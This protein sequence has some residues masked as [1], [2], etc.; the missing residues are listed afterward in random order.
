MVAFNQVALGD[1]MTITFWQR[2]ETV[3]QSL[4]FWGVS[5]T[6]LIELGV[7]VHAPWT[8]KRIYFDTGPNANRIVTGARGDD[9]SQWHHFTF[10]KAGPVKQVWLDGVLLSQAAGAPSIPSDFTEFW[11]GSGMQGGGSILGQLDDFAIFG[12]ALSQATIVQLARGKR[13]DE[14]VDDGDPELI[15][16]CS[17]G[18]IHNGGDLTLN[19]STVSGNRALADGGAIYNGGNLTLNDSTV[20]GNSALAGGGGI[21]SDSGALALNRSTVSDNRAFSSGG[22]IHVTGGGTVTIDNSTC[23]GNSGAM[24]GAVYA[25]DGTITVNNTTMTGNSA[26]EVGGAMFVDLGLLMLNNSTV[27]GNSAEMK[28]GGLRLSFGFDTH[29][30]ANSIVAGNTALSGSGPDIWTDGAPLTTTGV[31][32]IG[33]LDGSGLAPDPTVLV[34][35]PQLEPLGDYG[36]PTLTMQPQPGSP[37]INPPGGATA[38]DFDYDQRGPGFRR[39]VGGVLDIGAVEYPPLVVTTAVDEDDG[40]ALPSLGTGISLREALAASAGG[41]AIEF[42]P[43]LSGATITLLHGEMVIDKNIAISAATLPDGLTISGNDV[44][45][46]FTVQSGSTVVMTSLTLTNGRAGQYGGAIK[47]HGALTLNRVRLIDN[48]SGQDGGAIYN[49]GGGIAFNECTA[50]DNSAPNRYGGVLWTTSGRDIIVNGSTFSG[51]T[52][53]WG[54]AIYVYSGNLTVNNSTLAQNSASNGGAIHIQ[55]SRLTLYNSTVFGNSATERGG[56][57]YSL[58]SFISLHNAIMAGNSAALAPDIRRTGLASVSA[59]GV[60]LIGDLDGSGMGEGPSVRVGDPLLAPLG[61]YGGPTRTMLPLPGS[62]AIDAGGSSALPSDQRGLPRAVGVRVDIGAVETGNGIPDYDPVVDSSSDSIDGRDTNGVS[63]REAVLL[64]PPDAAITFDPT[65]EDEVITLTGGQFL[66]D[67]NLTIDGSAFPGGMTLSGNNASRLFEIASGATVVICALNLTEGFA[68]EGGAVLNHGELTINR[69]TVSGNRAADPYAL[70]SSHGGGIVNYGTLTINYSTVSDNRAESYDPSDPFGSPYGEAGGGVANH[71]YLT[72]NNSTISGNRASNLNSGFSYFPTE[73]GGIANYGA[74]AINNSTISG[75]SAVGQA[76]AEARG[77]AI[78]N[79]GSSLTLD[80]VTIA[81]NSADTGGGGLYS[82]SSIMPDSTLK[83]SII[84]GNTAPSGPDLWVLYELPPPVTE[85]VNLIGDLTDS[86]LTGG[87]TVMTGDPLLAPLGPYGGPTRTMRPLNQSPVIDAAAE[88]APAADQRGVPRPQGDAADIGAVEVMPLALTVDIAG[89]VD[90]GP[91]TNGTSLREAVLYSQGDTQITFDESLAGNTIL[92]GLGEFLIDKDLDL[93]ASALSSG[94]TLDARGESRLF[95]VGAGTTVAMTNLRLTGGNAPRGGGILNAGDLT[96]SRVTISGNFAAEDGGGIAN[97][98]GSLTLNESTVAGNAAGSGGGILNNQGTLALHKSTL[99]GNHAELDGGGVR[100]VSGT[101]A[102]LDNSTLSGNTAGTSGGGIFTSGASAFTLSSVTISGNSAAVGGGVAST[103]STVTLKNSIVAANV[104]PLAPDF[105]D[106]GALGPAGVNLLSDL[107]GTEL[108]AGTAVLVTDDP[109]LAP[110]GNYGGPTKTLLPLPDSPAIDAAGSTDPGGTDQRGSSRFVAGSLDIGAVEVKRLIVTTN[111]ASGDGSLQKAVEEDLSVGT[112]IGFAPELSGK[113]ITLEGSPITITQSLAVDGSNLPGGITISGD[114]QSRVFEVNAEATVLLQGLVMTNGHAADDGGGIRNSGTLILRD[115]IL[116]RSSAQNDGG[117]I[118]NQGALLLVESLVSNN[119]SGRHGGGIYHREGSPTTEPTLGLVESTITGN[120][121]GGDGGGLYNKDGAGVLD[122]STFSLNAADGDGGAILN[123]LGGSL[124]LIESMLAGNSAAGSGGGISNEGEVMLNDSSITGNAAALNGGGVRHISGSLALTTGTISQNTAGQAGGGIWSGATANVVDSTIAGNT[125][126]N[127]GGVRHAGGSLTLT[128]ATVADNQSSGD[129]GGITSSSGNLALSAVTISGNRAAASGGGLWENPAGSLRLANVLLAGNRAMN[130]N[131]LDGAVTGNLGGNLLGDGSGATGLVDGQMN[132]QVGTASEPIDPGLAPLGH[133]GGLTKT[134]ALL[135]GSPAIDAGLSGDTIPV[136]DQRGF[137]R[138]AVPDVGAAEAAPAR[139]V[140]TSA[141]NGSGSLRQVLATAVGGPAR[142]LFN[143]SSDDNTITLTSGELA[144]SSQSI[145]LDA[146]KLVD[147]LGDVATEEDP[148]RSGGRVVPTGVTISGGHASRVFDVPDGSSLGLH[149]VTVADGNSGAADGGGLLVEGTATLA[150]C[151][152]SGCTTTGSGGGIAS[153]G[154]LHV[155]N[156]TLS[157]NHAAYGGAIHQSGGRVTIN[158]STLANNLAGLGGGALFVMDDHVAKPGRLMV[159]GSTI[160]GN[161]A[162]VNGGVGIL[163]SAADVVLGNAIVAGN[164]GGTSPDLGINLSEGSFES[165]GGNLIGDNRGA[166]TVFPAGLPNAGGDLAGPAADPLDP[167]L[168]NLADNGGPTATMA[169]LP[170]SPAVDAGVA[171]GHIPF[172]DQRGLARLLA[173]GLDIGALEAGAVDFTAS[174]LTLYAR[175]P[176]AVGGGG[177]MRFEIST[178]PDFFPLVSTL[179]G[180]GAVGALDGAV[181]NARFSYPADLAEDV[182]GNLFIADSGNNLIRMITPGGEVRTIAGTGNFGMIDGIGAD[183]TFAFPSGLAVGPDGNLYVSDTINHV[184]RKLTR[185]AEADDPWIVSTLAGA[186]IAGFLDGIGTSTFFNHPHGIAVDAS[187]ILFVADTFNHC[188]RKISPNGTVTTYAGSGANGADDGPR[189]IARFSSPT[190][191]AVDLDGNVFVADRDN[192]RIRMI[193]AASHMVVTIAG[194]SAGFLNGDGT[195][196]QFR[197]PSGLALDADGGLVVADQGNHAIRHVAR[198]ID[199]ADP[200]KVSTVAGTGDGG[201][202][203]GRGTSVEAMFHHCNGVLVAANGDVL[204][205]DE[206][207]HRIRRITDPVLITASEVGPAPD[208]LM[209]SR[210]LDIASLGLRP[211]LAYYFR[212]AAVDGST[213]MLGASFEIMPLP[214]VATAPATNLTRTAATING[215]VDPNGSP[216]TVTFE[217]ST[218][219]DLNGPMTVGSLA[220]GFLDPEGV[221]IDADG[222]V[223]LA[224]RDAHKILRIDPVGVVSDFAGSGAAGFSDGVGA[225]AQFD[226]PADVAID[227]VG[228]V[229][230]A[231]E[232]NHRIRM[233]TPAGAVSTVAG[234][235]VA[236]DADDPVATNGRLLFP[237]GVA[238]GPEGEV[239]IADRGNHRIRVVSGGG[240][241]TLAGDGTPGFLDGPAAAAQFNNPTGVAV[242]A[243]GN[244]YVA[245][246]DNHR[247]RLVAANGLVVTAAGTGM[248]GYLDGAGNSARFAFPTGVAVDDRGNLYVA[249]YGNHRLRLIGNSGVVRTAAGSGVEAVLDSPGTRFLYP[250]TAAGFSS[251]NRVAVGSDGTIFLTEQGSQRVRMVERN[252]LR[253]ITLPE[254]FGDNGDLNLSRTLPE[255]LLLG[256]TYY[257][258]VCAQNAVGPAEGGILSFTTPTNP[259]IAVARGAGDVAVALANGQSEPVDFGPTPRGTP[260]TL[261]FTITNVGG[262]DLAVNTIKP[263]AG[264]QVT[265]VIEPIAPGASRYFEVT[266]AAT[267]GGTFGGNLEIVSND[268]EQVS[269]IFPVTGTVLDPPTL[270]MLNASD[271]G[272]GSAT[273]HATVNPEDSATTV[274]FEYS[275]DPNLEGVKVNTLAGATPGYAE[276]IGPEARFDQ[277]WG[278]ATD[279]AGNIYVADTKNHRIRRIAPDGTTTTIAGTG[280]AG[281]ANGPGTAAQFHEPLGITLGADG[282]LFVADSL[283]HLIRA[284]AA[285]G[286][287]R[288]HSGLGLAGFTD[289][290]GVAAR[291]NRPSGLAIDRDGTIYVADRGNHRIRKVTPDGVASTFAGSGIAGFQ[292]GPGTSAR[293]NE[294]LGIAIGPTGIVYLTEAVTHCVRSIAPDGFVSTLAGDGAGYVDGSG[295]AAR[296]RSPTGLAVDA[297]GNIHVADSGNHR[298]RRITPA[299]EVTTF[300]GSGIPGAA[301]GL[302][303]EAQF[304]LPLAIAVDG[305][306]DLIASDLV[307][308]T[309]RRIAPTTVVLQAGTDLNGT[310]DLAVSLPLTGLEPGASYYFRAIATN[311]GGTSVGAIRHFSLTT[312]LM[313]FEAWRVAQFGANAGDPLIAGP[314][315]DA[316]GDGV[317][318]LIKYAHLLDPNL[319]SRSGLPLVGVGNGALT[320]S[321]TKVLAATDLDYVVESSTNLRTWSSNGITEEVLSGDG[322]TQQ[323]LASAPTTGTPV[324]FI[325]LRVILQ[326]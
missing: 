322:A 77:G 213:Q 126:A 19:D 165:R 185:P 30:I 257:F 153:L 132:D 109:Q 12:S 119:A 312:G 9:F 159:L 172:T 111:A 143:L 195:A 325:R 10:V 205:A 82:D 2:L 223:Y 7:S 266:L 124:D 11:I 150:E 127:G 42:A 106:N 113:T 57:I 44:T 204:V 56:G 319:P 122:S 13:P 180:D 203:D 296:F 311:G 261:Q 219:P 8:D 53:E 123:G 316:S 301:D 160:S 14:L 281:F 89:D 103:N 85:G 304:N 293:F 78:Y 94:V 47:N 283:N 169:P 140:T 162:A 285:D 176:A 90:D 287:V 157:G 104:A 273:L 151:T 280:V 75:N 32:L 73:G 40:S 35:D 168:G 108:A 309:I 86:G 318:N 24:G 16:A 139:I 100:D 186:G 152:V 326:P 254:T 36:G 277:P 252:P 1:R 228:N 4:S 196:A 215:I 46:I 229:F 240:L 61:D 313:S 26:T 302:G 305:A 21:F 272:E 66:L 201:F 248:A 118:F 98:L 182:F 37:A 291:F 174:G 102:L 231:D 99:S 220:D 20:S 177:P 92:L 191:V 184:I 38:S 97:D 194:S 262:W 25:M 51:N 190:G 270:T 64:A 45:R 211:D 274:W 70:I 93:D 65:L 62:P 181:L 209:F 233:I 49:S 29:T 81:A 170:R 315:A 55:G 217:Y 324:K 242:D 238:V 294:P 84:A 18:A 202:L 175:V 114:G 133:Y 307:N 154:T 288:T 221:A 178:D 33:D 299:G 193:D 187:G 264:Y 284:I 241:S 58:S 212:W 167:L 276:G 52:A 105:F 246:R 158:T 226:H 188:I 289:G 222:N 166:E 31:N 120:A 43:E 300:A 149:T 115:A 239:L 295:S 269:F 128:S 256:S 198:P 265:D 101:A 207:N 179:A 117:G 297:S 227:A 292:N 173:G 243:F 80:H 3:R 245:D 255:T 96:M 137:P 286:Q 236:G 95:K 148:L 156:S 74:A 135:V 192:H 22:A 278:I 314:L 321:Y 88:P 298:I 225:A 79:Y 83:N 147:A 87:P 247:V 250:A 134:M 253:S 141:D 72:I 54:G 28:G 59:T 216:T 63:L 15:S 129:G 171:T 249:D 230:V 303:A 224:D 271:L 290:V 142:I 23:H 161:H 308:S 34:R 251:P 68:P 320:L 237:C 163:Q 71:G 210:E 268:P 235:G 39:V 232:L 267:V 155:I 164:T 125:A 218:D 69:S 199:P 121:A 208:G 259:A 206:R 258:R 279:A 244:V 136:T 138:V 183:A 48:E 107:S 67:K 110:L 6:S 131:D 323:I 5:P 275:L 263:P 60:N 76:P 306:G 310:T 41:T 282:S 91:F 146:S 17:G 200:W 189:L 130:S 144:L 317:P 27:S 214:T 50:S 145:L 260:V 116:E 234:S 197:N 112:I